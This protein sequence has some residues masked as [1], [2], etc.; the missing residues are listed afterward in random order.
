[1]NGIVSKLKLF[2]SRRNIC[3]EIIQNGGGNQ[4]SKLEQRSAIDYLVGEKCKPREIYRGM[5]IPY[6]E[7]YFS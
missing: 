2:Q 6:E 4:R 7:M 3:F 5:C 1:M